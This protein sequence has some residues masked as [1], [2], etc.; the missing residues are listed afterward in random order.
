MLVA[1]VAGLAV[2]AWLLVA[3][4]TKKVRD[5]AP[6]D[7]ASAAPSGS[8]PPVG[9]T[10]AP[11]VPSPAGDPL[12]PEST[13]VLGDDSFK[14]LVFTVPLD[15]GRLALV[16]L[17]KDKPAGLAAV[18]EETRASFV[19]NAGFFDTKGAP[20]GLGVS[21]GVELRA[22]SRSL[23]GGVL[24]VA[25]GRG[26][27]FPA[28]GFAPRAGLDFAIQSK[29]RLVVDGASNIE[30]DDG[31]SAERTALCLRNEGRT[32]EVVVARGEQPGKGPTLS[33]LADML[34]SRGCDGALN[35]DGGPSTGVAYRPEG[36]DVIELAPRGMI[37][38][39][40]AVWVTEP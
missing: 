38:E 34:V 27:L 23:G 37:R 33:L 18:R 11:R 10:D 40:L 14:V 12:T 1:S 36:G 2:F 25:E 22:G 16:G 24:A 26:A 20:E 4:D 17:P 30:R 5:A 15:R 21:R 31:K 39:A 9:S 28:E 19:I 35:L 13:S 32:L 3:F 7:A 6:G 8:P 29:P